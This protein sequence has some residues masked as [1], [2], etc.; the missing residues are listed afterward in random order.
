MSKKASNHG[1][2]HH[3]HHEGLPG[4]RAVQRQK[5]V[6]LELGNDTH[7][8]LALVS[9]KILNIGPP[10]TRKASDNINW[11]TVDEDLYKRA[12]ES[13]DD[14]L[15]PFDKEAR[16]Y[17]FES[18]KEVLWADKDSEKLR[19]IEEKKRKEEEERAKRDAVFASR[20]GIK[21]PKTVSA[22]LMKAIAKDAKEDAQKGINKSR[23]SSKQVRLGPSNETLVETFIDPFSLPKGW[24]I[25]KNPKTGEV[26]YVNEETLDRYAKQPAEAEVWVDKLDLLQRLTPRLDMNGY[27]FKEDVKQKR[28]RLRKVEDF[29]R[30]LK[31]EAIRRAT[32]PTELEQVEDVL[33]YIVDSL[34]RLD[35]EK[36]D[37]IKA[38]KRENLIKSWHTATL[39]Y[40]MKQLPITETESG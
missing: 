19:A 8:R 15:K 17:Y 18:V 33:F 26:W 5:V 3:H 38:A 23:P 1:H 39:G 34:D 36:R 14:V 6:K 32:N 7:S 28:V 40:K 10:P 9:E 24:R 4:G 20:T 13:Y 11:K 35:K 29:D 2:H 30:R 31:E 27:E 16:V 21:K 12:K 22:D 25:D 37:A